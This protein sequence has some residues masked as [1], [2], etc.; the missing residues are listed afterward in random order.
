MFVRF[1][2][3][4]LKVMLDVEIW[5]RTTQ[6]SCLKVCLVSVWERSDEHITSAHEMSVTGQALHVRCFC[7]Q[8]IYTAW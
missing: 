8:T 6:Y 1:Y 2:S 5:D 3:V 7:F 4:K